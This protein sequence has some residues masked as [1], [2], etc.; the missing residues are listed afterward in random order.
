MFTTWGWDKEKDFVKRTNGQMEAFRKCNST[1][2]HRP[3]LLVAL[4]DY[5]L[6]KYVG[7]C[8]RGMAMEY[9]TNS[10][11]PICIAGALRIFKRDQFLFLRFED[12]MRMKAPALLIARH[13]RARIAAHARP[14][15]HSRSPAHYRSYIRFT[16]TIRIAHVAADALKLHGAVH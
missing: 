13:R 12:L 9:V 8:F 5:E 7:K 10:L 6:F 14:P 2:F 4:P 16:R 15:A 3:D 1:L 11:Y